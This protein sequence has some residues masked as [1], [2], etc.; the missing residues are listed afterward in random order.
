MQGLL[1][2]PA[3]FLALIEKDLSSM[4]WSFDIAVLIEPQKYSPSSGDI[5]YFDQSSIVRAP[6]AIKSRWEEQGRVHFVKKSAPT[7]GVSLKA[8]ELSAYAVNGQY[9]SPPIE[10]FQVWSQWY[11][12]STDWQWDIAIM[13]PWLSLLTQPS[14]SYAETLIALTRSVIWEGEALPAIKYYDKKWWFKGRSYDFCVL[15]SGS[16]VIENNIAPVRPI[17]WDGL[18]STAD[19]RN[20]ARR[21]MRYALY[22]NRPL[23]IKH[24]NPGLFFLPL[25]WP[26]RLET[27]EEQWRILITL[28]YT[29]QGVLCF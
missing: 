26:V 18:N 5:N 28:L 23:A 6:Y 8:W 4:L 22:Q 21:I 3:W 24:Q 14:W 29:Y 25:F 17:Y 13:R 16:D 7:L 11:C 15:A 10:L 1:I 12:G 9:W 27:I 19:Y 20:T 2:A